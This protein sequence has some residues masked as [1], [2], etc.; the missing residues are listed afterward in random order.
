MLRATGAWEEYDNEKKDFKHRHCLDN[1]ASDSE[2]FWNVWL[3]D[4]VGYGLSAY[5][6]G[7][8]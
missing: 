3:P 1:F 5:A 6:V 8:S 2:V 4:F 7:I